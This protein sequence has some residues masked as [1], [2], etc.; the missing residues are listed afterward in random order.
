ME[1]NPST[2]PRGLDV[3]GELLGIDYSVHNED[4]TAGILDHLVPTVPRRFSHPRL[5]YIAGVFQERTPLSHDWIGDDIRLRSTDSPG[6]MAGNTDQGVQ[7]VNPWEAAGPG[8]RI[9]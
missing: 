2:G 5:F 8:S 7:I 9:G 3:E 1:T 4:L 6:D